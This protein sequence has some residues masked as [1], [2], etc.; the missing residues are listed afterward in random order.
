MNMLVS[1]AIVGTAIPATAAQTDPAFAAIAKK[2]A[3]DI[4]HIK[5][6]EHTDS[7]PVRFPRS[8]ACWAA[9]DAQAEACDYA[10]QIDWELATTKPASLAGIAAVLRFVNEI[11]DGG[12]EWPNSDEIGADGWHY[13]LRKTMAAAIEAIIHR[14]ASI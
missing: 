7:F 2:K 11:E 3:A 9:W 14:N 6:I 13:Q 10:S 5:A 4:A 8:E 1:T 12:D